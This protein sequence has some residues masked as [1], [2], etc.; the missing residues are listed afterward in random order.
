MPTSMLPGVGGLLGKMPGLGGSDMRVPRFHGTLF[1]TGAE[2]HPDL[3]RVVGDIP[4][5]RNLH[6][7]ATLNEYVGDMSDHGV[8]RK[9]GVPFLFFSCGRWVHYHMPSDVP[10][11]LNYKKM[12]RIAAYTFALLRKLDGEPL[13]GCHSTFQPCDTTE[14]EAQTIRDT[15]GPFYSMMLNWAGLEE[16]RTRDDLEALVGSLMST[17]L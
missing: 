1:M 14:F 15:A 2:S 8:F 5:P 6:L 16:L 3:A 7:M 4:L 10:S 12:A 13:A 11:R 17:G 9:N